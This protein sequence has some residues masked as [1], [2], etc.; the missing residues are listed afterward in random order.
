MP[1]SFTNTAAR[2]ASAPCSSRCDT[3]SDIERSTASRAARRPARQTCARWGAASQR[4]WAS[5]PS[6]RTMLE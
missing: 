4:R 5:Q 1:R 3:A 2:L 6:S